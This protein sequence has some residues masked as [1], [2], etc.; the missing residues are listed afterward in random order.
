MFLLVFMCNMVRLVI[1]LV[2]MICVGKICLFGREILI[3]FVLLIMWL[4]VMMMFLGLMMKLEF[5]ELVM[6]GLLLKILLKCL[7]GEFF[8]KFGKWL[9]MF[10]CCVVEILIIVGDRCL[11]RLVNLFGVGWVVIVVGVD[12][13]KMIV[14]MGVR[15]W[16][17]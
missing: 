4:L 15:K 11:V 14:I 1:G 3:L 7:S 17:I 9:L 13:I 8:G 5:S 16:N 12:S 2:L 6:C 10:R